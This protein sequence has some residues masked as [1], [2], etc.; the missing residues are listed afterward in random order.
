MNGSLTRSSWKARS[1]SEADKLSEADNMAAAPAM[2]PPKRVRRDTTA[3]D[4]G[5]LFSIESSSSVADSRVDDRRRYEPPLGF[6]LGGMLHPVQH[7]VGRHIR[8]IFRTRRPFMLSVRLPRRVVY[9]VGTASAQM[10]WGCYSCLTSRAA[11]SSRNAT[12]F[13]CRR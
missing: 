2:A 8:D 12:N 13:V 3:G 6:K 1:R 9:A 10:R 4:S 7:H 5:C 11:L